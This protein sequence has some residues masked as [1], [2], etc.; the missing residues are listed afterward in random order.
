LQCGWKNK[1]ILQGAHT[2]GATVG[3]GRPHI[4][5]NCNVVEHA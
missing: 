5:A 1:K 2:N 3:G 4:E